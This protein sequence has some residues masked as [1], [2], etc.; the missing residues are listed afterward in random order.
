M[1]RVANSRSQTLEEIKFRKK[2]PFSVSPNLVHSLCDC[3][4]AEESPFQRF[5]K[6]TL[7]W[8]FLV[9]SSSVSF[10]LVLSL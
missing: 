5:R 7:S 2:Y 8:D 6:A 10:P 4:K 9:F 3:K 1:K